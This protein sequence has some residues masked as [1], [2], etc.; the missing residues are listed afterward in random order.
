MFA[1]VIYQ[2]TNL[3]Q[4]QN[5]WWKPIVRFSFIFLFLPEVKM[6]VESHKDIVGITKTELLNQKDQRWNPDFILPLPCI[7]PG[8]YSRSFQRHVEWQ[9]WQHWHT[10]NRPTSAFSLMN[11]NWKTLEG[12]SNVH[13][14]GSNELHGWT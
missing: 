4:N 10:R 7:K 11:L 14:S 3:K 6:L 12:H 2:K 13:V 8:V 9:E 1:I 5:K